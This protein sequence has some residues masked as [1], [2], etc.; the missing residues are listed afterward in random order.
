[1]FEMSNLTAAD[2]M[3]RDVATVRPNDT[4]RRAAQIMLERGVSGLPVVEADGRVVGVVSEAD[5]IRQDES[6]TRRFRWWL[7][8]LA[9]GE[10]LSDEFLAA[11][12][13][14]NRPVSKV[15]RTG[16]VRVSEQTPL[17]EV[18]EKI[19]RQNIRRVLV[20]KD[21]RLAGVVARRDLVK[22]LA[23]AK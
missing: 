15:M 21:D 18:A 1:M 20:M 3:T 8:V 9:E 16:L 7:D 14:I 12:H 19:V 23:R 11:I 4:L 17:R 13:A 5:L 2:V 10:N 6:Q 22:V